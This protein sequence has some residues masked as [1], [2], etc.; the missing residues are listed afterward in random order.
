M[1]EREKL[2]GSR[3]APSCVEEIWLA[4]LV[5]I[6]FFLPG[7]EDTLLE[8]STAKSARSRWVLRHLSSTNRRCRDA[9]KMTPYAPSFTP[10]QVAYDVKEGAC[11]VE[12]GAWVEALPQHEPPARGCAVLTTGRVV[13]IQGRVV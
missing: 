13:Q 2:Y 5:L 10:D 12:K 6:R 3:D 11:G 8:R 7:R 4:V 9:C 1:L